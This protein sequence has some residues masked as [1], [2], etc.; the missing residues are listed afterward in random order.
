[1]KSRQ[2]RCL[3]DLRASPT[4]PVFHPTVGVFL[5]AGFQYSAQPV[6]LII[7]PYHD[8]HALSS[9][10]WGAPRLQYPRGTRQGVDPP[11]GKSAIRRCRAVRGGLADFADPAATIVSCPGGADGSTCMIASGTRAI[12]GEAGEPP[13]LQVSRFREQQRRQNGRQEQVTSLLAKI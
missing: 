5:M 11:R 4:G 3:T 10:R 2:K 7:R 1:M 9:R 12:H 6:S 13:A 8:S